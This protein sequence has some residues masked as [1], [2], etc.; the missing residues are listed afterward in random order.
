[1]P[2]TD[3]MTR[4]PEEAVADVVT[5]LL[6][7]R[8]LALYDVELS[9]SG[10]AR[11]LRVLVTA[12]DGASR[13]DLDAIAASA[14]AVSPAL[15]DPAVD[16]LLPSPY[17]LELSSPGLE[18]PLRRPEHYRGAIGEQVSIKRHGAARERGTVAAADDVSFELAHTDGTTTRVEYDDVDKARTVFE[19]GAGEEKKR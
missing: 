12:A 19:W 3:T 6:A 15:D 10:R 8:G 13:V 7:A 14:E 5:P 18:R 17:A 16:R 2:H 9:G 11:V 1:M 4:T